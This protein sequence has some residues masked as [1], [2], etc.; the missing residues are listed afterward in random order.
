MKNRND[1]LAADLDV[2]PS[3]DARTD[4]TWSAAGA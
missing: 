1:N 4:P 3:Q 2:L